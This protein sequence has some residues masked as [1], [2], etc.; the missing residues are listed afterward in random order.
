M[1]IRLL[2]WGS[3]TSSKIYS[4]KSTSS[5]ITSLK[6]LKM[7]KKISGKKLK[8]KYLYNFLNVPMASSFEPQG[9]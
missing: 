1:K 6:S 8:Q 3:L 5:K 2:L 4:S 7:I 9:R